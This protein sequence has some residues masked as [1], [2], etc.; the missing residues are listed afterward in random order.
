[1]GET[2][3]RLESSSMQARK[4]NARIPC[5]LLLLV[6]PVFL[7]AHPA[8]GCSCG[9]VLT[10]LE[11]LARAD[12]VFEGTVTNV[13]PVFFRIGDLETIGNS[14]TFRV[15]ARW[16]GAIEDR[17][18]LLDAA[19]NCSF[20]FTW[21]QVYTVFAVQ[22]PA[23]RS[24]WSATICS[25]TTED[26]SYEDRKSLGP[27]VQ[28]S[29]RHDPIPPETLVHSAAR[30]FVLGVHALRYFARDWYEGLGDSES[31]VVLEYSLA[32]LCCG[33]LLAALH[34]ARLR[35][36][37]WLLA[38]YVCLP[39]VLFLSGVAWGYTAVVRN[40]MASYMAY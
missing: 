18:T 19:G 20:R 33:Y 6:V 3:G 15:D 26:L 35:R 34:L 9:K 37:R 21:G 40:P 2:L 31:R 7:A 8:C 11:G 17:L 32:A 13:W 5:S 12:A 10:P 29:T 36:W 39:F 25:P 38:L 14:Y 23:D 27:P 16:K 22:D 24:R 28:L 30:R 4:T 1:M